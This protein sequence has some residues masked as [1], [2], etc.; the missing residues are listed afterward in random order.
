MSQHK[1]P[2]RDANIAAIVNYFKSGIKQPGSAPALGVEL[3]HTLLYKDG[4]PL[5]YNDE[6]GQ[7]WILEQLKDTFPHEIIDESGALIGLLGE[8]DT[9]G[10]SVTLEPA[11]QLELSAGPFTDLHVALDTF[12]KFQQK[13]SGIVE[14]HG[15]ELLTPGYHP[16]R[17]AID[18]EMIPKRRYDIMNEYL[19]AISYYGICMMRGSA[20]AQVSIDY[21]SVEDCL[22]KLRLANACVPLFSLIC[23][24]SPVFEGELRPHRM[25][26]T[27][28]WRYCDP[29]RCE[30]VPNV[31][32]ADFTLETYAQYMLDTPAMVQIED[33][34]AIMSSRTNG[35]IFADT[36]MTKTDIDHIA[37]TF[38]ND[39]RLKTYIEIRPADAMP[40]EY[41]IAYAALIKGLFYNEDSLDAMDALF[42]EGIDA[43]DIAIAKDTLM[44]RGYNASVYGKPVTEIID[45]LLGIAL[46]GLDEANRDLAQPIASLIE[47]RI[48]LADIALKEMQ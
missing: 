3:E 16:T 40:A 11:A 26:R 22:R 13:V 7:K 14:S 19:G 41:A 21:Y 35:D 48:T 34:H 38:F 8:G 1:Q 32:D 42:G 6:Y 39:V 27:V 23:D 18:L 45:A 47:H 9:S 25:M 31:M 33:G 46:S 17:R 29:D 12:K 15:I 36:P 28:C 37:A 20:S 4:R 30:T 43:H 24:N 10:A 5:S 2:A 44:Q